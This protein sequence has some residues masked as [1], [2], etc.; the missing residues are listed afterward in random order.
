MNIDNWK[1]QLRKGAAELAILAAL[2][3]Q[4]ASGT[5]LVQGLAPHDAL[6]LSEGT[7]YP[8]LARL[9]REGRIEGR[10]D[11]PIGSGRPTKSYCLTPDGHATLAAMTAVWTDFRKQLSTLTGAA[12]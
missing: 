7:V 1:T 11:L 9:E 12:S 10:W 2:A 5:T 8:L 3:R 6:G 4:P